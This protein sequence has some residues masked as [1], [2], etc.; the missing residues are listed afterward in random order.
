MMSAAAFEPDVYITLFRGQTILPANGHPE[1]ADVTFGPYSHVH[2]DEQ[3]RVLAIRT[4]GEEHLLIKING[5]L[6]Y[7]HALYRDWVIF[8]GSPE[9]L[10]VFDAGKARPRRR[11]GE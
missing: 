9:A 10:G 4:S 3:G 6:Y 8:A 7:N 5:G 2:G 11:S 1:V